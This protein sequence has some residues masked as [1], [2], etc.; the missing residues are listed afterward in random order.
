MTARQVQLGDRANSRVEIVSGL[1]AG[2]RYVVRSGRPLNDGDAV[3]FSI[4]SEG[5]GRGNG[6]RTSQSSAPTQEENTQPKGQQ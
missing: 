3:R 2:E 5:V 4:L 6:D 1:Q